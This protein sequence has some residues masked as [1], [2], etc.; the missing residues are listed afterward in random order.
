MNNFWSVTFQSQ[1]SSITFSTVCYL[2][3]KFSDLVEKLLKENEELKNN[4]LIFLYGGKLMDLDKTLEE[5]RIKNGS[6][7]VISKMDKNN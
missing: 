4:Q 6:K 7:I 5:N 3:Q 2:K 1:D